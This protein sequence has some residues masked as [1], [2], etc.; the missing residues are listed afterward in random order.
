ML[1]TS[2]TVVAVT[3]P[4]LWLHGEEDQLVPMAGSRRGIVLLINANVTEKT[5]QGA[6]RGLQRAQQG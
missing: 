4:V 1:T 3:G 6:A 2:S 5:Y